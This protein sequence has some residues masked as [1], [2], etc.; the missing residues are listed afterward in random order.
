MLCKLREWDSEFFGLR[1]AEVVPSRLNVAQAR[2]VEAWCQANQID[3]L[4]FLADGDDHETVAIAEQHH[5]GLKDVRLTFAR[6]LS[7]PLEHD[8]P[9]DLSV[10]S[11]STD[12][13][14]LLEAMA[15][16]SHHQSR[17]YADSHF[18][19]EAAD[20]LYRE[21]IRKSCAGWADDVLVLAQSDGGPPIGYLTGH[22]RDGTG[23]IGIIAVSAVA[24]GRGGGTLLVSE[25]VGRY[26]AAGLAKVTVVTQG[27]NVGAQR[28]YQRL[29]FT[30]E[31]LELWYHR[32][33][34]R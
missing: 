20:R 25:V 27:R 2:E 6:N 33:W 10:R 8:A 26:R 11:P 30:T 21:W 7:T 16:S 3:C 24:R 17:F 4:Y 34:N 29:G 15:A 28:L 1:I 23:Q 18:S 12:D 5:F 32:W 13:V 14:P 9:S 31:K 22:R 19:R